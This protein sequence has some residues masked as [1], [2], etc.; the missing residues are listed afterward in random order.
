MPDTT[1][2]TQTS[3]SILAISPYSSLYSSQHWLWFHV[4]HLA[5]IMSFCYCFS[6]IKKKKKQ[7]TS[8]LLS[9]QLFLFLLSWNTAVFVSSFTRADWTLTRNKQL[10][11]SCFHQIP[12]NHRISHSNIISTFEALVILT[13]FISFSLGHHT[14]ITD[15]THIISILN[16]K[17]EIWD[18]QHKKAT[19]ERAYKIMNLFPRK[20]S[21]NFSKVPRATAGR[22]CLSRKSFSQNL[23][24]NLTALSTKAKRKASQAWITQQN[25]PPQPRAFLCAFPY[26]K[27]NMTNFYGV[28]KNSHMQFTS[29]SP[30][31][32][33]EVTMSS[34]D[35]VTY[36]LLAGKSNRASQ[37]K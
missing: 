3:V 23:K 20:C 2:T 4:P 14:V 37:E 27:F 22:R 1:G 7:T 11:C 18:L 17:Q 10:T 26:M 34:M 29:I 35:G 5:Y 24:L 19:V 30:I 28:V 16:L 15:L 31:S 36:C 6:G 8:D 9:V 33:E 12:C 25:I 13:R 32:Q 21:F